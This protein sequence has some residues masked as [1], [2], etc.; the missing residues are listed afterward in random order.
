MRGFRFVTAEGHASR[1]FTTRDA[2]VVEMVRFAAIRAFAAF[3]VHA[4]P[5]T[6]PVS[7]AE[8][9]AQD[10]QRTGWRIESGR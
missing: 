3:G 5:R 1:A 4:E 10:L 2:A 9:V 8:E 7:D 6:L